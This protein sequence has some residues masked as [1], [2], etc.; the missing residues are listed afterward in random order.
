M[1]LSINTM[2]AIWAVTELSIWHMDI[3][4]STLENENYSAWNYILQK[5]FHLQIEQI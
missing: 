1:L 2:S 3:L 4:Y 5:F